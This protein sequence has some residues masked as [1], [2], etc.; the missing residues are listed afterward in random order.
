MKKRTLLAWSSGKDSAWALRMLQ[1]SPD[2]EIAGLFS[3]VNRD[4]RRVSMHSV[5]E[6]ILLLQAESV[7]LPIHIIQIPHLCSSSEYDNAMAEFVRQSKA[8][9]IECMAFGDLFLENIRKYRE[10][11]L[12]NTGISPLFPLWGTPTAVLSREIAN[13]GMRAVVTC[14]DTRSL[15]AEYAGR[16]YDNSF[17]DDL[18]ENVDPCGEN[19]EFHSFVYDGPVFEKPMD[20]RVGEKVGRDGFVFADILIRND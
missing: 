17:L 8:D 1:S 20:I 19:G 6:E 2:V 12:E 7:D 5:R 16:E 10:E 4:F 14:V 18:P 13:S 9:G 15:S 3:T 11:R